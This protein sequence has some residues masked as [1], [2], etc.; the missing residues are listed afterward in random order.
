M[1]EAPRP[2]LSKSSQWFPG[3]QPWPQAGSGLGLLQCSG[4]AASAIS[5]FPPNT[6]VL[7]A[8]LHV[9]KREL[10]TAFLNF[11]EISRSNSRPTQI[12]ER[13]LLY[14]IYAVECGL[15]YLFLK[16]REMH[17]TEALEKYDLRNI[18]THNLNS[19]LREVQMGM[20]LPR[21]LRM[22]TN[23][24]ISPGDLHQLYRYG[25]RLNPRCEEDL[26]EKL[27]NIFDEIQNNLGE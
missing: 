2:M 27:S 22:E 26:M 7:M 25:G 8:M 14:A 15:K 13:F 21:F 24:N 12:E 20:T 1:S 19:L 5:V 17:T 4:S 16:D 6:N 9:S 11:S 3:W 18:K 10:R 23:E